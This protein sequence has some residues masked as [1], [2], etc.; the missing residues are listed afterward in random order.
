MCPRRDAACRARTGPA[1]SPREAMEAA[2]RWS[3]RF[4][5]IPDPEMADY[6]E[7]AREL[8][9]QMGA[10]CDGHAVGA[11]QRYWQLCS[12][13]RSQAYFV[14]GDAPRRHAWPQ[15]ELFTGEILWGDPTP[16]YPD[17]LMPPAWW[18]QRV[19]LYWYRFNG[20]CFSARGDYVRV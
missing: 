4:R 19:P 8:E 20:E 9:R 12:P 6:W 15:L 10:D 7:T 5:Y 1:M 11:I 3:T 14:V 13:P 18:S 16:G 17:G 2:I